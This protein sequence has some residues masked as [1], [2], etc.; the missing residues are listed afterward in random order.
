KFRESK[1]RQHRIRRPGENSFSPR[2][3]INSIHLKLAA[4]ITPDQGG[5]DNA[6]PRIQ[7]DEAVHL[8]RKANTTDILAG[9]IGFRH[10]PAYPL[11]PR[12]P[13]VLRPLLSPQGPLHSHVFV[14]CS[15]GARHSAS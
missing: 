2:R 9:D 3:L 10:N 5:T 15:K 1:S 4:L 13:P 12:T 6:I 14:R 11:P 8:A 7:H